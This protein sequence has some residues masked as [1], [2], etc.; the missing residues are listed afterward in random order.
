MNGF[1]WK[2]VTKPQ[3][4]NNVNYSDYGT[5]YS[6]FS[7][8]NFRGTVSLKYSTEHDYVI[9]RGELTD[10]HK[11]GHGQ[12]ITHCQNLIKSKHYS[13]KDFSWGDLRYYEVGIQKLTD[14]N[15]KTGNATNWVQNSQNHHIT[16]IDK[17]INPSIRRGS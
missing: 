11:D 16:L 10:N 3:K 1:F 13:G 12:Y 17:L 2:T 7:D 9:Y 8:A 4:L 15:K 6:E 5:K 14:P